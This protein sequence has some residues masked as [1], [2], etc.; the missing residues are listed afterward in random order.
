MPVL[1]RDHGFQ[2]FLGLVS[3]WPKIKP[4]EVGIIT[5]QEHVMDSEERKVDTQE[6]GRQLSVLFSSVHTGCV[7]GTEDDAIHKC[8]K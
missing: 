2:I 5:A 7:L 8:L 1:G 6:F 3:H 4:I